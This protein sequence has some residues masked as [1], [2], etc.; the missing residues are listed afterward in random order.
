MSEVMKD[1]AIK[2]F[3][4]TIFLP[5]DNNKVVSDV[6]V[7]EQR[8]SYSA[9]S[10][11]ST[12]RK[13]VSVTKHETTSINLTE[14]TLTEATESSEKEEPSDQS[15]VSQEKTLKK[16]DKILPCPRC[17]SMD[18]KF[19]Y[20]NNYNV[21]QPRHFCKKCQRYWTA[22]GTMRNVPVGSGRRKNNKDII[23]IPN[24]HQIMVSDAINGIHSS[25]NP[26]GFLMFDSEN[27]NSPK[28]P[29]SFGHLGFP[30]TFYSTP[31]YWNGPWAVPTAPST[32]P[33]TS[34]LGKHSREGITIRSSKS[35]KENISSVLIPKTVRIDDPSEGAKCS[36]WSTFGIKN[37][38]SLF[39]A[40]V[41]KGDRNSSN[42]DY[43]T[44]VMQANPAAL[45]RSLNFHESAQ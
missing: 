30:I 43:A 3:G 13:D 27:S 17:N 7:S 25:S 32:S 41:S 28:K 2:L 10:I 5:P 29:P 12:D 39:K 45:S 19:C 14:E 16:P 31:P 26:N 37:E 18:T 21:N 9:T 1:S 40:F 11:S 34:T 4:M 35:E 44:M 38:K 42:V 20:Y 15:S 6:S 22:G 36:I 8:Q 33:I 23:S 24:Y